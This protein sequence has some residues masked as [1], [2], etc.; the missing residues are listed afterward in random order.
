MLKDDA[1]VGAFTIYRQE[2]RPFTD[3]Q[4]ALLTNFAAQAVI[5]TENARL[6]NELR[7]RTD[8]LTESLQQQTATSEVFGVISKS[9]GELKPVFDAV[10]ENATRLCEANFGTLYRFENG[11]F[12]VTALRNVPPEFAAF[13]QAGPLRP[14]PASTLSRA[15][16]SRQPTHVVD[17]R[18]EP[19]KAIPMSWRSPE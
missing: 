11:A 14:S 1:L 3:R 12:W 7:Q 10:L 5:A 9:P 18:A 13:Q 15:A 4:I 19:S 6:L 17:I 16:K 2:V 8:A